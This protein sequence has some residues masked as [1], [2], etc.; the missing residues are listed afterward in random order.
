MADGVPDGV[1]PEAAEAARSTLGGA[2]AVARRL[3]DHVGAEL[4][5]AAR[6]AFGQAFELTVAISAIVSL[7]TAIGA[8]LLLRRRQVGSFASGGS[9]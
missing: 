8:T 9:V 1:P 2:L 6:D 4:L 5:A 3:P 7:A